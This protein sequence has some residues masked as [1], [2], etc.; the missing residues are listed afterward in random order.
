MIIVFA[1]LLLVVIMGTSDKEIAS[2]TITLLGTLAGYM[3]NSKD[4]TGVEPSG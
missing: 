2:S 4:S 1:A 3:L